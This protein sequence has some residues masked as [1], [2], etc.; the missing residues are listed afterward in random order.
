V[1][2]HSPGD[3]RGPVESGQHPSAAELRGYLDDRLADA[4]AQAVADHLEACERCVVALDDLGSDPVR[5]PAARA[6][7]AAWDERRMRRS[8]RHTVL[9]T[10]VNT[11]LLLVL[12]ALVLQLLGWFVIHPLLIDRGDRLTDHVTATIDVPVMTIPGAE[13]NQVISNPGLL[14]RTTEVE[15]QRAVGSQMIPLGTFTTRLGPRGMSVP[16]GPD[17][18]PRGPWLEPAS[19]DLGPVPFEPDRLAEGTAVTVELSWHDDALDLAAA[20][21]VV[22]GSDDLALLWVGFRIPGG[23]HP[24]D[25]SWQLGYSACG[26]VPTFLRE[27]RRGGFGG[28]GDFRDRGVDSGAQHALDELRRATANLAAI[29]WPGQRTARAGALAD[30]T[31][32]AE[33]LATSEPAVMSIVITGPSQMVAAAVAEHA[34]DETNLL[35]VDFD[36]GAPTTCA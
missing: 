22:D 23:E 28:G 30:L 13:L 5:L 36:R 3:A 7:G 6:D 12:A 20:D 24:M 2:E 32:T 26:Q 11:A 27:Q 4:D 25:P 14:G 31:G 19:T 15:L 35:E 1:D 29:G 34:P 21:A 16:S 8:V 9:L 33:H 10:A 17:I 18:G